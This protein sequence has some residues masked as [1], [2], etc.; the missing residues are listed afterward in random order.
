[1]G[2][3]EHQKYLR[4]QK[5]ATERAE[6]EAARIRAEEDARDADQRRIRDNQTNDRTN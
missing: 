1:M 4:E 6:A 5:E 3:T 2:E